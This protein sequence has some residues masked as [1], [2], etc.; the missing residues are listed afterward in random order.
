MGINTITVL[1]AFLLFSSNFEV[2][3]FI[4]HFIN[5]VSPKTIKAISAT[6]QDKLHKFKNNSESITLLLIDYLIFAFDLLQ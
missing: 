1:T 6:S 3:F 4:G 5:I 2:A